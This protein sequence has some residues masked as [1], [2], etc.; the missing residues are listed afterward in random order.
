MNTENNISQAQLEAIES[1][2]NNTMEETQRQ[3]FETKLKEDT[4]FKNTFED[5]KTLLLGIESAVLQEQLNAF[6]KP[7]DEV[8]PLHQETKKTKQSSRY[9]I[10]TIAASIAALMGIFWFFNSTSATDQLFVEHF[11]P[12]PGLPTVMSTSNQFEFYDAMVNYKQE[13]YTTA[14]KKWEQILPNKPEND[15]LNFYLGVSYLAEGNSQ[16]A[17]SFFNK[18]LQSPESIFHED[19]TYYTALAFIKSGNIKKAKELL[20]ASTSSKS[21]ELLQALNKKL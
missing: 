5:T 13:T 10:Y 15:T 11:T 19:A 16:K 4:S 1:Y 6:H 2:L 7:F 9:L 21:Q 14:I 18:T 8:R 12:D 17:T 20:Q 3:D